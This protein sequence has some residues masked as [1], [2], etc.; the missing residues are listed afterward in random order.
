MP[1]EHQ[2]CNDESCE[3]CTERERKIARKIVPG[4]DRAMRRLKPLLDQR[5]RRPQA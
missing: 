3:I 4:V 5:R 2:T 1:D